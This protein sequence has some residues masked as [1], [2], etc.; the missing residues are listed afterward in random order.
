MM[1]TLATLSLN[2]FA[3]CRNDFQGVVAHNQGNQ[4]YS[5]QIQVSG[6]ALKRGYQVLASALAYQVEIAPE[7]RATKKKLKFQTLILNVMNGNETDSDLE[8][9]HASYNRHNKNISMDEFLSK[10]GNA[11]DDRENFCLSN[12]ELGD[13]SDRDAAFDKMYRNVHFITYGQLAT[14]EYVRMSSRPKTEKEIMEML[15]NQK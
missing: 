12:E 8:V 9:L 15:K 13:L 6:N 1:I 11:L 5:E 10:L 4:N 14:S 3:D 7:I 2:A